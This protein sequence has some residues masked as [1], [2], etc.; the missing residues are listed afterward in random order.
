MITAVSYKPARIGTPYNPIVWSVVSD[1]TAQKDF[2]YVID[3][4]VNDTFVTRLRQRPNPSGYGMWDVSS[5]VQGYLKVTNFT[6]GELESPNTSLG[7]FNTNQAASVHVY[8]KVGEQYGP[9]QTIRTGVTNAV[10]DPSYAV[11][12]AYATKD[13]QVTVIAGSLTDHQSLW[14]MQNPAT[15]GV[16]NTDPFNN[17]I[18]YE[19]KGGL[20]SPLSKQM[21]R[22][23][24]GYT[25]SLYNFDAAT[26]SFI[27]Y[28]ALSGAEGTIYGFRFIYYPAVGS[29]LTTDTVM[30]TTT[31]FGPRTTCSAT[32]SGQPAALYDI[33]HINTSPS[34]IAAL[35]GWN[36][37][38]GDKYSIQGYSKNVANCNFQ[39]AITE[40]I[41]YT[42]EEYCETLYPRVRL[43]WLNELAGRDYW[44]FTMLAEK[45]TDVSY[46][47]YGQNQVNWSDYLPVPQLNSTWPPMK[48]LPIQGGDKIY[49]K[50]AKTTWKIQ[51]DWLSQEELNLMDGLLKS[52]QV[53]AYIHDEEMPIYDAFPYSCKI[54]DK[55]FT[56]QLVKQKKVISAIFEIEINMPQAMQN[57]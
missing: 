21:S 6:Q 50:Y 16:W 46:E 35:T 54:V 19:W 31:G 14:N 33:V 53:L 22:N 57:T 40:S 43:S 30:L 2:Q 49:N 20:A 29:T 4:Y 55:S 37:Q 52:P 18:H 17:Y 24:S 48:T 38:P 45:T 26:A 9:S 3:V 39:Y 25:R 56:T 11:Y 13:L 51:T 36:I 41:T 34:H 8:C 44:N 12:S 28:S 23:A 15:N 10:G 47:Q 42:V 27:N 1:Q 32:I 7:W 5:I